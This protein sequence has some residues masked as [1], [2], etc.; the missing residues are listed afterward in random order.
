MCTSL[1]SLSDGFGSLFASPNGDDDLHDEALGSR[2]AALNLLDLDLAHLG[3]IVDEGD[4]TA[5][6]DEAV[7]EAGQQLQKLESSH[8][9]R[10]KIDHLLRTHSII[11]GKCEKRS[12]R[13]VCSSNIYGESKC[14]CT[15]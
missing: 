3:V 4:D 7:K 1:L 6:I 12:P 11:A 2:I 15:M 9:A 13:M 14:C 5:E 8:A 10:D